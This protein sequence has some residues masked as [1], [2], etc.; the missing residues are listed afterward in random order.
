MSPRLALASI[1]VLVLLGI[2]LPGHAQVSETPSLELPPALGERD[3]IWA[4]L[5]N[6]GW[7]VP[8]ERDSICPANADCIYNGGLNVR[9]GVERR[10]AS[11]LSFGVG[12]DASVVDSQTVY[13]LGVLQALTVV[14]KY[15]FFDETNVHPFL[16]LG[17]GPAL[18]GD[19]FTADTYGGVVDVTGGVELE[20]THAFRL[21]VAIPWRI[22]V[23]REFTT[24]QDDVRRSTSGGNTA[25]A[26]EVGAVIL[27]GP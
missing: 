9:L 23:L 8:F 10:W 25:F 16:S 15:V 17:A 5:V 26:V 1:V 13:E 4:F 2:G 21:V 19:T 22:L 3:P 27:E 18:F 14:G 24:A 11:G 6:V 12:Y 20:L 7:F